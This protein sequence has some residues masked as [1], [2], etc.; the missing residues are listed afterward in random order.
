MRKPALITLILVVGAVYALLT[1]SGDSKA[2]W[3]GQEGRIVFHNT[4]TDPGIYSVNAN[5]SDLQQLTTGA[6]F[7]PS[8][9]PDGTKIAFQR[10]AE[11]MPG[12]RTQPQGAGSLIYIM[13]AN[14]DNE[15]LVANGYQPSWTADGTRLIFV[16]SAEIVE[17]DP[18]G[19]NFEALTDSAPDLFF[20]VMSPDGQRIAYVAEVPFVANQRGIGPQGPP[21]FE[22]QAWVMDSNSSNLV[23]VSDDD[24]YQPFPVDW[25][26]DS[27]K[28]VYFDGNLWIAVPG[29]APVNQNLDMSNDQPA[30]SPDGDPIVFSGYHPFGCDVNNIVYTIDIVPV[31]GNESDVGTI[32][33]DP[34]EC[35]DQYRYPD[36]QPSSGQ[37]TPTKSPSPTPSPT[38][39]PTPT[40]TPTAQPGTQT[41]APTSTQ[42][43]TPT[44][45][46]TDSPTPVGDPTPTPIVREVKW[47][48]ANCTETVDP[49]DS[50]LTLRHDAGL[51]VDTNDCPPMGKFINVLQVLPAGLE[52]PI[53]AF[54][55]NVD[56]NVAGINPVDSLMILRFDAH[57]SVTQTEPCPPMGAGVE[58]SYTP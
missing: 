30:F 36:W 13:D 23:Q 46:V 50:L 19:G 22:Y 29:Q 58:I 33:G 12:A 3:P 41:P 42:T 37:A 52:E 16:Q 43:A 32:I 53:T 7:Y 45:S 1:L 48:D 18:D 8:W 51:S 17:T 31:G 49:V 55:G 21:A 14:G 54:W 15:T 39:S 24:Y 56:C 9:S 47:A 25:S 28:L 27:T 40:P 20:P 5:G 10:G 26:P 38:A 44:P 34:G 6:D 11:P 2:A 57:L 35:E 4:G